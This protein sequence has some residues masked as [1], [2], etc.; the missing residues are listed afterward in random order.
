M[1]AVLRAPRS[2]WIA[3]ASRALGD[4]GV[5]SVR[6]ESL[7]ET[8]GVTK[9]SFY[10]H[11]A[12]RAALLQAVLDDWERRSTADVLKRVEGL[13]GNPADRIRMAG[14]LTFGA[15]LRQV[16]L[17]VRD[18]ARSDPQVRDRLRRVD[19]ARMDYL[20]TQFRGLVP[21]PVEVEAKSI[22]A[23]TFAIGRHFL[24]A[25]H[26]EDALARIAQL[27]GLDE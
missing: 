21:D 1:P 25:A 9:G 11:F 7:A 20:R 19:R 26:D 18:W 22:L 5:D 13:E 23:F 6:V 8:I 15:E 24:D 3:E 27:L 14:L 2:Q 4:G 16:D 17:A 12:N 10:A